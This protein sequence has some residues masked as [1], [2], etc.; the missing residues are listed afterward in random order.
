MQDADAAML[1]IR[2]LKDAHGSEHRQVFK[3]AA[4]TLLAGALKELRMTDRDNKKDQV[5]LPLDYVSLYAMLQSAWSVWH[6]CC[7][8]ALTIHSAIIQPDHLLTS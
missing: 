3:D 5:D 6:A 8:E 7:T 4:W 1:L 2:L